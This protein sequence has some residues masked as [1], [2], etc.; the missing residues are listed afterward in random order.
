MKNKFLSPFKN[1]KWSHEEGD[2]NL[3][4]W[5]LSCSI[6][7]NLPVVFAG[8]HRRYRSEGDDC[9]WFGAS[10]IQTGP[11]ARLAATFC[12][13]SCWWWE[14]CVT[15]DFI[16]IYWTGSYGY[17]ISDAAQCLYTQSHRPRLLLHLSLCSWQDWGTKSKVPFS[18]YSVE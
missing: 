4:C 17:T 14:V 9:C 10:V 12:G 6:A 3:Q 8:H 1:K 13:V 7:I 5:I 11:S 15:D 18:V 16:S 2:F